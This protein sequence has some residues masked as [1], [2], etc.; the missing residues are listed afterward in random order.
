MRSHSFTPENMYKPWDATRLEMVCMLVVGE[1]ITQ[2]D[3]MEFIVPALAYAG[4]IE[5][6]DTCSAVRVG[7]TL[8]INKH[9]SYIDLDT[10]DKT[11]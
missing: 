8:L 10:K 7:N 11:N 9:S 6:G 2:D 1:D 4:L 3:V 5:E